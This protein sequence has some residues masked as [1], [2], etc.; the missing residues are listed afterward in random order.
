ME[1]NIYNV[2]VYTNTVNKNTHT[3]IHTRA[4]THTRERTHARTQDIYVL[5]KIM[6]YQNPTALFLIPIDKGTRPKSPYNITVGV[7]FLTFSILFKKN[8]ECTISIADKS[9]N[10]R[11][12]QP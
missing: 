2:V 1:N 11:I 3:Q 5:L 4:R 8:P 7:L 9:P 10:P 12:S 6:S